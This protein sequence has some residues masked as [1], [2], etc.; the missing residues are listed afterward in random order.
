MFWRKKKRVPDEQLDRIGKELL[1]V[2]KTSEPSLDE[3][4]V[5]PFAYAKLRTR[6][7]EE[8]YKRA[9]ASNPWMILASLAP[10]ALSVL[11]AVTLVAVGSF[12]YVSSTAGSQS[13]NPD[14]VASFQKEVVPVTAISACS[15]ASKPECVVSDHE[16]LALLIPQETLKKMQ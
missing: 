8:Q 15:I 10:Q 14:Q 7:A 1:Q 2:L 4:P 12:W 5:P 16:V 6:I 9:Q 11:S 3:T 13:V